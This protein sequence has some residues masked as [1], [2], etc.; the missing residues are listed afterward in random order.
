MQEISMVAVGE[1]CLFSYGNL[2]C[3][4]S[5]TGVIVAA[6]PACIDGEQT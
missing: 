3:Q 1:T 2:K 4:I 6:E 5:I